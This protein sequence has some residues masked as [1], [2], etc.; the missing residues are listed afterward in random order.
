MPRPHARKKRKGG[1][2]QGQGHKQPAQRGQQ[3]QVASSSDEDDPFHFTG[4]EGKRKRKLS[5]Q[6]PIVC[7]W[8]CGGV[9]FGHGD[10]VTRCDDER[11]SGSSKW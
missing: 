7:V 2:Q 8:W 3:Q 10:H 5:V 4:D 1:G 6:A 9:F 11:R